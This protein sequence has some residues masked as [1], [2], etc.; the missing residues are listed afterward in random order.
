M[1]IVGV[2]GAVTLAV[3]GY[4][5]LFS[6]VHVTMA[7]FGVVE[8]RRRSGAEL[9]PERTPVT[10][11]VPAY[12]EEETILEAL[13]A[14]LSQPHPVSVVFVDDGSTDD[15]FDLVASA[16][17]LTRVDEGAAPPDVDRFEAR[18]AEL[19]V[20]RQDN[21]GKAA[22]LNT[23][24]AVCDTALFCVV[25]ADTIIEP[26]SLPRLAARFGDEA[27]V[28][29]EG[30]IRVTDPRDS[31]GIGGL[32]SSWV[33]RNQALEQL[34]AFV[35]RRLGRT[36]FGLMVHV[37]G[38]YSMFRTD[39]VRAIGGFADVETEDFDLAVSLREHCAE[40]G[41]PCRFVQV[42]DAIAWT[43][44]PGT[45]QGLY[46]QRERWIQ[47][48]NETFAR[49]RHVF[50]NP[51]YGRAGAFGLPYFLLGEIGWPM[52]EAIGYVLVPLA[53]ILGAVS[54]VVPVVFVL[55]L[56]G[57]G[58]VASVIAVL[59]TRGHAEGYDSADRSALLKTTLTERLWRPTQVLVGSYSAV[60]YFR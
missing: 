48:T 53:W 12:N 30:S 25:D 3:V 26:S 28:A 31:D 5:V 47:G 7:L 16:Y 59:G 40:T 43:V 33:E 45:A 6:I 8:F 52:T 38:A 24:L 50:G 27:T 54:T 51:R 20:C 4:Y 35:F 36:R 14:V 46:E 15:T 49:H 13:S 9:S 39:L 22:A 1:R 2:L 23:G 58:P 10:V 42:P 44:V 11:A 17:D 32:P 34:R 41:R 57:A 37:F 19:T 29:A 56:V 55:A 21:R 60:S 18:G